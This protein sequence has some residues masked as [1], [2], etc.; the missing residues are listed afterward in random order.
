MAFK[1]LDIQTLIAEGKIVTTSDINT[2]N[3]YVSLGLWQPGNRKNS[4]GNASYPQYVITIADL[5]SG[6]MGGSV[7][8][9]TAD[10][11]LNISNIDPQ[12]PNLQLGGPLTANTTI[13]SSGFDLIVDA[14]NTKTIIGDATN[15]FRVET[16]A[17]IKILNIAADR[18]S[19][20]RTKDFLYNGTT[21]VFYIE[22]NVGKFLKI[23]DTG[24]FEFNNFDASLGAQIINDFLAFNRNFK[25]SSGIVSGNSSYPYMFI[26]NNLYYNCAPIFT[27]GIGVDQTTLPDFQQNMVTLKLD[28]SN[29]SASFANTKAFSIIDSFVYDTNSTNLQNKYGIHINMD[30]SYTNTGAGVSTT[31][32][33]YAKAANADI[34]YAAQFDGRINVANL[35]TSSAGLATGDLWIDTTAG[36]VIK[37]A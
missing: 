20:F 26:R 16:S 35:P 9:V 1:V 4:S 21:D 11:G 29:T 17:G 37:V 10:N 6:A 7:Q 3:A 30:A 31:T 8:S 2:A 15:A 13:T 34:N 33:L 19:S 22:N 32:A 12:N 14:S 18:T 23:T 28:I 36:N 27:I 5:L 24:Q 25:F